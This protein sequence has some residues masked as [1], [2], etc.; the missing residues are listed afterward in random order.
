MKVLVLALVATVAAAQSPGDGTRRRPVERNPS[1]VGTIR[2]CETD[3]CATTQPHACI[4]ISNAETAWRTCI[5]NQGRRGLVLGPTDLR[6]SPS[7][8][9]MRVLREAGV[10]EIFVPYHEGG[11]RLYDHE[12]TSAAS[13][14]E[15]TV[16]DAG[17]DGQ[18]I[19]LSGRLV[20][21][22]VAE[23]NDRGIA[24]LC[25]ERRSVS[26]RGSELVLWGVQDAANYDF[27]IEYR[28]RD[29]GSIG[30]RLGATGFNNPYFAGGTTAPHMHDALWRIDVDLNGP[31]GDTAVQLAH[32][33]TAEAPRS[34]RD[35]EE[36]FNGGREGVMQ[37][38]PETFLTIGVEDQ[39]LNA[40]GNRIGYTLRVSANGIA[41]HFGTPPREERFTLSD[42]AVTTFKQSERDAHFDSPHVRYLQPD[43]YLLGQDFPGM[44][45]D[46]G[47][48]VEDTDIV[49]WYRSSAHHDPHDEDHAPGD[50]SSLMTG[51]TNVHWQGVDLEPRNLFDSNPLGGPSRDDC[52]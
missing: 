33:E 42:F 38:D 52:R 15:V 11:F 31:G 5:S 12:T 14:R 23:T 45:V 46:D 8:P 29:D 4:E 51:I 10:A 43:Q 25:K 24:W 6:R 35:V 21:Q 28:L 40:H 50:P 17:R 44:G 47:E 22:V 9:W 7:E 19:T 32:V 16:A 49:L 48:P 18:L 3:I 26:R 34:A 2:A 37:R 20:P 1:A 13:V 41:R 27:L 39:T 36:P 30:F